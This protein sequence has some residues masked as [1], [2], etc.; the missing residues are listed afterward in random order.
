[1]T[2]RR[3]QRATDDRD[4]DVLV[5]V[6]ANQAVQHFGRL[7][8]SDAAADDDALLD[9][10]AGCVQRVI[11][12]VFTLFH[13]DFGH[14]ANADD[15]DAA[16]QFGHTLLQ[17]FA[18][19]V[20]GGFLDLR[21]DLAHAGFDL[22]TLARTINDGGRVF[23]DRDALGRAQHVDRDAF[24]LHAEVFRDHLT[25]GQD[26]EVL[27]HGL[28]AIA[29][30]RCLDGSDLQTTAQLVDDQRGQSLA[31]DVFSD[32]Q[33]R[34]LRLNDGFQQGNH[35]LQRR[36]FLLVQQDQHVIEVSNH[37]VG[38]GDKVGRQEATVEL[39][40]FDNFD[41]SLSAFGFFDGDDTFVADFLHSFSDQLTDQRFAVGR[42]GAD[43]GNFIAVRN[44]TGRGFQGFDDFG[45]RQVDAALQIHRVQASR[46]RLQTFFDDRLRQNGR[47]G[48]AVAGLIIGASR[49][50]FHELCAHVFEFVSQFDFFGNRNAVLGDARGTERL[51]DHDV[52]AFG[53]QRHFYSIGEDVDAAQHTLA[54]FGVELYVLG[55]HFSFPCLLWFPGRAKSGDNAQN[56]AFLHDQQLFTFDGDLGARPFTEQNAVAGFHRRCDQLA[57]ILTCAFANGDDFA[58]SGL[59]FCAIGD[60]QTALGLFFALHTAHDHTVMKRLECHLAAPQLIKIWFLA[61][62]SP[63]C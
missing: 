15:S 38:V 48:G 46:N 24:Q 29:K 59:F 28:A 61:L 6:C 45:G 18:V 27:Q 23:G 1:M 36:E 54:G 47:S 21:A 50:F 57:R 5:A 26:R 35:R 56:V 41:R 34:L 2:D 63:E 3:F 19:V 53:A 55:S 8:Q 9:S 10:S 20:R 60:D 40:A 58:L 51:V 49:N 4:T 44:G 37:F 13:F 7:N 11:N 33:Q 42:D 43:L 31:F 32:D 17:L 25:T 14:A 52:T 62:I 30:A 16:S 22:G 12:A 39:H